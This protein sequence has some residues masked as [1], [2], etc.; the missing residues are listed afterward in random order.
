MTAKPKI[1]FVLDVAI[2]I[3]FVVALLSGLLLDDAYS[4]GG[5][6]M[7]RGHGGGDSGETYT[8][9]GVDRHAMDA[10][11][12]WSSLLAGVLVV[13]HLA[14]H[15]K[16]LVCQGKRMLGLPG[17]TRHLAPKP[18]SNYTGRPGDMISDNAIRGGTSR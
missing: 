4:S 17:G 9:L 1:N 10:V 5:V 11:H 2:F 15:W 13:V 7:R 12:T 3:L 6:Q 18:E 16:W 14:L 8:V